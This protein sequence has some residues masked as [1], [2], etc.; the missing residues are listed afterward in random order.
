MEQNND[1]GERGYFGTTA[2]GISRG[3]DVHDSYKGEE[4]IERE[5]RQRERAVEIRIPT[6]HRIV[7]VYHFLGPCQAE[8]S[9]H[10]H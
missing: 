4:K 2:P 8:A 7:R 5:K 9:R 10:L 3:P 1:M 6:V